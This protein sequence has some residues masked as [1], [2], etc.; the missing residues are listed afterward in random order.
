MTAPQAFTPVAPSPTPEYVWQRCLDI[1]KSDATDY[2]GHFNPRLLEVLAHP[3]RRLLDIGCASGILGRYVKETTPGAYVA[4]I[5]PNE[6]AA[7]AAK[8]NLDLVLCGK[9]EDVDLVGAGIPHGSIDTV[10]AADVLEH[11]YDPWHVLVNLKPFLTPD[12]QLIISIP[13]VRNLKLVTNLADIGMWTYD[14]RGLLDITHIRFFTL[15]EMAALLTQTGYKLELVSHFIDKGLEDLYESAQ[16]KPEI[17][18]RA[19]RL[20]LEKITMQELT[21]LCT[22]QFFMRARPVF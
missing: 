18:V 9:F 8:S 1:K 15:K 16:G 11:M 7:A 4:G 5:E 21:E 12:A 6:A 19:G 20:S 10:V 13:N 17:N 3:P 22:W 14:E 2:H